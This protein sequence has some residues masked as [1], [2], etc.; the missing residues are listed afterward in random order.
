MNKLFTAYVPYC[1]SDCYT[2]RKDASFATNDLTFHGHYIVEAVLDDLI[3]NTWITEAEEVNE[4]GLDNFFLYNSSGCFDGSVC[5][6]NRNRG[7]L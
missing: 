2:G 1:S 4:I 3:Q 5:R 6:R 7:K